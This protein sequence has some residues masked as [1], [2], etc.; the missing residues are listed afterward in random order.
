MVKLFYR[1]INSKLTWVFFV[2]FGIGM[3]IGSTFCE[4]VGSAM[5][6]SICACICIINGLLNLI[7]MGIMEQIDYRFSQLKELIQKENTEES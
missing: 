2:A 5:F 3:L 4:N 6:C 1:I 7:Y